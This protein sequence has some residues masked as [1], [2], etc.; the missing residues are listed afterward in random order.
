MMRGLFTILAIVFVA[1]VFTPGS[2]KHPDDYVF[3]GDCIGI[4][5]VCAL[6]AIA[7]RPVHRD[8]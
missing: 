4:A 2:E 3:T 5:A 8:E 7:W 6:L 1:I